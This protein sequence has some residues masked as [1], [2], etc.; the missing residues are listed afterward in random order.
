M[1]R[2]PVSVTAR[3]VSSTGTMPVHFEAVEEVLLFVM[4][5]TVGVRPDTTLTLA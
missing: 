1:P 3:A 2:P 5:T 4:R